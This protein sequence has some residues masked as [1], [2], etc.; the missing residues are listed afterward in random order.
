MLKTFPTGGIHPP[1]NKLTAN[2][3]IAYLSIPE[4]VTIPVSQH[5]G[6]PA[7]PVVNKG[8][9]VKT[10]QVIA[11]WKGF[12]SANMHSSVSGKVNKIDRSPI[13]QDISRQPYISML[14]VMNG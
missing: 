14:K 3:A 8:D 2:K 10:G 6:A 1:E 13:A 4:S 7:I 5:I 11:T 12:V 9:Y